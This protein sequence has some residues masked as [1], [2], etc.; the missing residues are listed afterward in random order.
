MTVAVFVSSVF[1]PLRQNLQGEVLVVFAVKFRAT[2]VREIAIFTNN[3]AGKHRAQVCRDR[4]DWSR[5]IQRHLRAS[6]FKILL[7][8]TIV[9][10]Y[11]TVYLGY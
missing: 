3:G 10:W 1:T 4:R 8:S 2:S 6:G 5:R 11:N 9:V 7:S